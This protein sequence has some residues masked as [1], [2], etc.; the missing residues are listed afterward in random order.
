MKKYIL[1]LFALFLAIPIAV[2]SQNDDSKELLE[3]KLSEMY[4]IDQSIR[5]D[6]GEINAKYAGKPELKQKMDSIISLMLKTDA[7]NQQ[8]I[9][10]LLDKEGWPSGLS[11]EGNMAIFM[12]I[13]HAGADY[14]NK[15]AS[16]VE[17]EYLKGTIVPSLYAIFKDRILMYAD[18]P[19]IYGSQTVNGYVWP[20]EDPEN[21]DERREKMDLPPMGEYLKAFGDNAVT[22]DKDMTIQDIK[23]KMRR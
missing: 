17:K 14:M 11:F 20:I 21:V 13:Q 10:N 16:I 15:Y 22:W 12:I 19:Q 23:E 4:T 2:F 18:K 7:E 8:F 9:S 1:F 6:L 5:K 3:K